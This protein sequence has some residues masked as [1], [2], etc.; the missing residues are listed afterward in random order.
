MW[1][2]ASLIDVPNKNKVAWVHT[3]LP[4]KHPY[5][6]VGLFRFNTGLNLCL[7]AR[8]PTPTRRSQVNTAP[9]V[10]ASIELSL[11][12]L[13]LPNVLC[14]DRHLW[15]TCNS[16]PGPMVMNPSEAEGKGKGISCVWSKL[17]HSKSYFKQCM[18]DLHLE[19]TLS[20]VRTYF[21]LLLAIRDLQF[22]WHVEILE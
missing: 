10:K 7:D 2:E 14:E 20:P 11:L 4:A 5:C 3:K 16:T 8:H 12:P 22:Q 21:E 19:L 6:W 18:L 13:H 17:E 9:P 1:G 15:P